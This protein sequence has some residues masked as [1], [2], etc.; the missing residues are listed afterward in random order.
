[1]SFSANGTDDAE[2]T[3]ATFAVAGDYTFLVTITDMGGE[4]TS[5][6][7]DVTV[8]QTLTSIAVTPAAASLG[9][10]ATQQ[11][12][13]M[14]YDQFGNAMSSQPSCTWA[15]ASGVGSIDSA[16][17]LYRRPYASGSA[18]VTASSG[19]ITSNAASVT[20]TNAAPTRRHARRGAARHGD[21]HHDGAQ[22]AR[23]GQRRR[24]R[25]EP[26]LHLGNDRKSAGRSR[27]S[28]R[29]EPM[30]PEE[31]D[32]DICRGR[33]LHVPGYD[34]RHGRRIDHQ[35]RQRD[36]QPDAGEHCSRAHDR[37]HHRRRHATV[38]RHRP[39]PVRPDIRQSVGNVVLD[40]AG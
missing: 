33:Q 1:M 18:T 10:D 23:R 13:A 32:C 37:Q 24:R 4:S 17:G 7:V 14:S 11:L 40:R 19:G 26:D 35:Q 29:M 2:N 36:R 34:H 38:H 9:S 22:R 21:W 27:A 5:S 16:S 28:R 3:T 12:H 8:N 6:S 15:V 30:T 20:V 31:S 39:R 25:V